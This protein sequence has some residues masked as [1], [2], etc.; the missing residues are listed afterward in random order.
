MEHVEVRTGRT[1]SILNDILTPLADRPSIAILAGTLSPS[2]SDVDFRKVRL[3]PPIFR[4]G[5]DTPDKSDETLE[6]DF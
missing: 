2:G 4:K 6:T 1:A 5:F 3:T